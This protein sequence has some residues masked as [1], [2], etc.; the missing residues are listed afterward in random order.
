[1]CASAIQWSLIGCIVY[2]L[3]AE[4]S[5]TESQPTLADLAAELNGTRL[6]RRDRLLQ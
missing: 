1:M 3:R 6:G 5:M 2:A 4:N